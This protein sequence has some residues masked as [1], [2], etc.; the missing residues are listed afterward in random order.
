LAACLLSCAA[1]RAGEI[2]LKLTT[3]DGSSQVS[4]INASAANVASFDSAGNVNF[5]SAL[6]PNSQPGVLGQILESQGAGMCPVW[7]SSTVL[8]GGNPILNQSSI[9][10]GAVLYVSSASVDGQTL[11]ARSGGNVGIG[12]AS[13]G[14][15]LDVAGALGFTLDLKPAGQSGTAGQL[16]VSNG[17]GAAPVWTSAPPILATLTATSSTWTAQQNYNN[18]L[19]VSSNLVVNGGGVISGNGSGLTNLLPGRL[20][21]GNLPANVVVSSIAAG[22]VYPAALTP[23]AVGA[24]ALAAGAVG[25]AALAAGAVGP[26]AL[27]TAAYSAITGIGTQSQALN[28]NANPINGLAAPAAGTDA[29]TKA[30]VDAAT[31]T[32]T[33][34]I[35]SSANTWTGPQTYQ[36]LLTVSTSAVLS[37]ALLAN[38]SPGTAGQVL[39]SQGPALAPTWISSTTLF[40]GT[41]VLKQ[42]GLAPAISTKTNSYSMTPADFGIVADASSNAVSINLPPAANTGMLAYIVRKDGSANTVTIAGSGFDVIEGSSTVNL[43]A[44]FQKYLLQADGG[45][46]WYV[47]SQ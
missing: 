15:K 32:A 41:P 43:T 39:Q 3:S 36:K 25:A 11:L 12:T 17:P 7:V 27:S 42:G 37:G 26:T 40:G 46:T 38:G 34:G 6:Q 24:S 22:A 33:S 9:Q 23:G 30:Y 2:N 14:N 18:Q 45:T 29:A 8:L 21:A 44:K 47:I 28:M 31:A 20:S 1:L 16:L 19:T 35:L 10:S 4:V 13:P 5:T